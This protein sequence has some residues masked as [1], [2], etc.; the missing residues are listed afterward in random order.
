L[1][2]YESSVN[3]IVYY[4]IYYT[5]IIYIHI[6][7]KK[8]FQH[9]STET[10]FFWWGSESRVF[11]HIY[12]YGIIVYIIPSSFFSYQLHILIKDYLI[13]ITIK[14]NIN[15]KYRYELSV[16]YIKVKFIYKLSIPVPLF[17]INDTD[18]VEFSI[19][20]FMILVV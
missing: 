3:M 19:C 17:L 15:K 4:T 11:F 6:F 2:Y 13:N 9:T 16:Y 8:V 18:F 14:A 7:W 20:I 12:I 5:S 1:Y 10:V